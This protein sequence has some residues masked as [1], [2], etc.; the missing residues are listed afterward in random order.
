MKREKSGGFV[1]IVLKRRI[2]RIED[3][4][5]GSGERKKED[6]I[7]H[8]AL[9]AGTLSSFRNINNYGASGLNF[10]RLWFFSFD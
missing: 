5:Q 9:V 8:V 4:L 6:Q 7:H 1:A 10:S 2:W 3:V